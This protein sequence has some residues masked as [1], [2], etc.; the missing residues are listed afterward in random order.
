MITTYEEEEDDVAYWD[1]VDGESWS[2]DDDEP[3]LNFSQYPDEC[4]NQSYER[5]TVLYN[6]QT[7][8][9]KL[10]AMNLDRLFNPSSIYYQLGTEVVKLS[11]LHEK[12]A[13]LFGPREIH[14]P[15]EIEG[16]VKE[17]A[18]MVRI[19]N[20]ISRYV[21]EVGRGYGSYIFKRMITSDLSTES[22]LSFNFTLNSQSTGSYFLETPM[23]TEGNLVKTLPCLVE[24][25]LNQGYHDTI[26]STYYETYCGRYGRRTGSISIFFERRGL[27]LKENL[28]QCFE[29]VPLGCIEV[30]IILEYSGIYSVQQWKRNIRSNSQMC[31]GKGE[32]EYLA[33]L[34]FLIFCCL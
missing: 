11:T 19:D 21:R 2:S 1:E 30:N 26:I 3:W 5:M 18:I 10:P 14:V 15:L 12:L 6:F 34:P 22:Y 8:L 4:K 32:V 16:L 25:I 7:D 9:Q 20:T 17:V 28:R 27:F 33:I 23:L 13:R 31:G 24:E 29:D